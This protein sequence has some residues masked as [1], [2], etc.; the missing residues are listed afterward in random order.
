[1]VAP[2]ERVAVAVSGGPDSIL[3]LEFMHQFSGE[4]GLSL[5][6]A[7]FNHHLRGD[8]SDA[9]ERFVARRAQELGLQFIRSEAEVAR[10]A[11][12]KRRNLE[13]TARDLRYRFFFSLV[14]Q[15]KVDKVATAHT[16]N[17]QAETVLLRLL[18]GTGTRGLGGIYPALDGKVIRPFLNLTRAEIEP[19]IQMRQLDFRVDASNLD[20]RFA[21]NRI[22]Q[23][24]L[25]LLESEFSPRI[26]MLLGE[27]AARSRDDEA[28]LQQLALERARAWR[29]RERN[30]EKIAVRPLIDFHPAIQR[31]ILR[32]M[33]FSA[34]GSLRGFTSTHIEALRRFAASSQSGKQL[35]LPGGLK[36]ER[37]FEWLVIGS[38]Q[39]EAV[40]H[41]FCFAVIPPTEIGIPQLDLKFRFLIAEN[42][43]SGAERGYN[44]KQVTGLDLDKLRGRLTLRNWQ[45]GDRFKPSGS[46]RALKLKELF[47]KLRVPAKSRRLWPVLLSNEQIIWVQGFPPAQGF[48]ASESSARILV[49]QEEHVS[50]PGAQQESRHKNLSGRS[51]QPAPDGT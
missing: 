24:L 9:D 28:F 13:A 12:S 37:E 16:A 36:A 14:N 20:L 30:Q 23:T 6:I 33:I 41:G 35:T 25:P 21:R 27:L 51:N 15:Q 4:T 43:R 47:L 39:N 10:I 5:V 40:A 2:G 22:R 45:A 50:A 34:S 38:R 42:I 26:V 18:R 29:M 44:C 19:E 8:D 32:E 1:M 7:H 11:R 49:V 48:A 46:R 31:R 3:L 17:D